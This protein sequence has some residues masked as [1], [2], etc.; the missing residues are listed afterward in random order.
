[1]DGII[2]NIGAHHERMRT[3]V[4]VIALIHWWMKIVRPIVL[5]ENR[6]L[7]MRCVLLLCGRGST[8]R[9][10]ELTTACHDESS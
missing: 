9:L 2:G 10:Y 8:K 4:L 6:R 5:G 7:W 3:N 1:M